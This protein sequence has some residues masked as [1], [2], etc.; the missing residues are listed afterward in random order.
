MS[1]DTQDCR[2]RALYGIELVAF[3][4]TDSEV[5]S[6]KVCYGCLAK[7]VSGAPLAYN[8]ERW[9]RDGSPSTILPDA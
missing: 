4:T 8:G 7:V 5:R 3:R 6:A 2:Q 9:W 1:C